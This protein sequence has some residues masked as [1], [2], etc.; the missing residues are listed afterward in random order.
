M[1]SSVPTRTETN[2]DSPKITSLSVRRYP[3]SCALPLFT[4]D[5]LAP[6]R[7]RV[8][9]QDV[10][11]YIIHVARD[12]ELIPQLQDIEREHRLGTN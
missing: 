12:S 1:R 8:S 5:F 10:P 9:T 4:F 7:T 3:L 6:C 2:C 11:R